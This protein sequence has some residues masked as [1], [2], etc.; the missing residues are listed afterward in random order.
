MPTF[1]VRSPE[2][3]TFQIQ[4]DNAEGALRAFGGYIEQQKT[5]VDPKTLGPLSEQSTNPALQQHSAD[6]NNLAMAQVEAP[7][8]AAAV[9]RD[10]Q[11]P[12][13]NELAGGVNA[14][15]GL[16]NGRGV[17]EEY[18][19]GKE[20]AD[21]A[22]QIAAARNPTES[23]I[24]TGFGIAGNLGHA[25]APGAAA[26]VPTVGQLA[27]QGAVMG[28]IGGVDQGEG[29]GDRLVKGLVGA[30]G[31]AA[32][33][34]V[35]G[36]GAE[37]AGKFGASA[38][39]AANEAVQAADR[40]GV[41]LPRVL[42]TDSRAT[43]AIGEGL[44]S[45]YMGAP[46][47]KATAATDAALGAKADELAQ[48]AGTAGSSEATGNSLRDALN[49]YIKEKSPAKVGAAYDALEQK[50][51][52]ALAQGTAELPSTTQTAQDI[53]ARRAAS[54]G[55]AS[56]AVKMV[57]EAATRPEGLT[58]GGIKDLRGRVGETTN[59][60]R[61]LPEGASAAEY[62]QLYGAL[63]E[64]LGAAAT[65]AGAGAEFQA[66]N[67]LAATER[68]L[69][70]KLTKIVGSTGENSGAS[71]Y[72]KIVK[73]AGSSSRAD[74]GQLA[75]VR[76]TVPQEEWNNLGSSIIQSLGRDAD[77]NF[78]AQ[79]FTTAYSKLS[80]GGKNVLFNPELRRALDDLHTVAT[81]VKDSARYRNYSGTAN[82]VAA[83]GI[84]PAA[85]ANP[86]AVIGGAIGTRAMAT[87]LAKPVTVRAT[88]KWVQAL[89]GFSRGASRATAA[90][91]T[92]TTKG[93]AKAIA[94]ETGAGFEQVYQQLLS[95]K[96]GTPASQ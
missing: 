41:P 53:M 29:L 55:G 26:I 43:Q 17:A 10:A 7:G 96:S 49:A 33:G 36:K 56:P 38:P 13:S 78:T 18:S 5:Y 52:Q 44:G 19:R 35:L 20:A 70:E 16:F 76:S 4:G 15:K 75:R 24:G 66:A 64:D 6:V 86:L 94:G 59:F 34:G 61:V 8:G 48:K 85:I 68:N 28:A 65:K 21:L 23:A 11:L 30:A 2:G 54:A 40:L 47:R 69:N 88:S 72:D 37:I 31:G 67:R 93:L 58:F 57:E 60:G 91:L 80:D 9:A 45:T 39:A 62:K 74:L 87:I 27:K 3:K 25:G 79:R 82:A 77:G 51:G 50:G 1:E 32:L 63:S 42:A 14:V 83:L 22:P 95:Q 90:T 73:A 89:G 12:F 81:K 46:I 84:I 92:S 71:V